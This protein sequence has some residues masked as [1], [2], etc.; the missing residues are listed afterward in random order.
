MSKKV[1][2]FL[3][4]SSLMLVL[5]SNIAL[6]AEEAKEK[7][8]KYQEAI[9]QV[10]NTDKLVLDIEIS[11]NTNIGQ[12]ADLLGKH[13]CAVPAITATPGTAAYA[14]QEQTRNDAVMEM[15]D[16]PQTKEDLK[17]KFS[18]NELGILQTI[19]DTLFGEKNS[20]LT[21]EGGVSSLQDLLN[22]AT[23]DL[24]TFVQ[25]ILTGDLKGLGLDDVQKVINDAANS[26]D[27]VVKLPGKISKIIG[28]VE[29]ILSFISFFL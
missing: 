8:E 21:I 24:P 9:T 25:Q 27:K 7:V 29:K 11:I 1:T 17:G 6:S 15:V 22:K 19:Y 5:M 10:D 2:L 12:L 20:L 18:S 23:S 14:Q 13:G 16:D 3:F 26:L 4:I 28:I